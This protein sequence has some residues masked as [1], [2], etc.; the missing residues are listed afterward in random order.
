MRTTQLVPGEFYH[1]YNR[2]NNKQTVFQNNTD[3]GRFL[4]LLLCLQSPLA[5]Q[6][7]SRYTKQFVQSLVL[8]IQENV[9]DVIIRKRYVDLVCFSLMPNH[10]HLLLYEREEEG[11][12]RYMHRVLTA[13]TKYVNMKY[14]KSGHV[15]QGTFQAVHVKDNEQLLHLSAYIHR[16]PREIISWQNKENQYPWSSYQDYCAKNRWGGLLQKGIV[17]EQ[18]DGE[19]EYLAFA[20]ESGIKD[21]NILNDEHI[22]LFK[23]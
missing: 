13:Y 23:A 17:A 19:N 14:K 1:I 4:F 12:S 18:F 21:T 11:I 10:F 16:N 3:F 9:K 5:F 20:R 22:T 8:N 2:G 15:F 6:N 7:M